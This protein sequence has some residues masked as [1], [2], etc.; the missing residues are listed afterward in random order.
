MQSRV[1]GFSVVGELRWRVWD[2]VVADV[3]EVTCT[4]TATGEY[5]SPDPR[6][7]VAL[8]LNPGGS[9]VLSHDGTEI[10]RHDKLGTMSFVPAGFAVHGEARGL[11]RIRHLDLH[12]SEAAVTRRFG[13]ALDRARLARVRLQIDD[14]KMAWLAASI[15]EECAN[16]PAL[17]DLY[18]A[19]LVDALLALLF[20]VRRDAE[21][22]RPGLSRQQLALVTDF[23]EANCFG[24]IRLGELAELA[25]LSET[26]FS[27]AFK[28]ST[29]Q[30]PHRW[31]MQA[32]IRKVQALLLKDD[33]NLSEIA[34][35]AGF[36]D[37]AHFTRA[38]KGIVGLTPA[39]WRRGA[40]RA[41][42]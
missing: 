11:T 3:W 4:E 13:K 42:K 12:F 2:G 33:V 5:I 24:T 29:G 26:Y 17:H 19:G 22:R 6:L 36:A 27:H 30:P 37:Q 9:F 15:A 23:I 40:H 41:Q 1:H 16:H 35:T 20:D 14:T 10:A 32:R 7:F 21:R 18:G 31:Q 38:F 39:E 25:R 34:T 8:D 28:A